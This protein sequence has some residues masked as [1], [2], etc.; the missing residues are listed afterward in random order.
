MAIFNSYVSHNQAGYFSP[1]VCWFTK[2]TDPR[3]HEDGHGLDEHVGALA[4]DHPHRCGGCRENP[5]FWCCSSG[6]VEGKSREKVM[7][8]R[9]KYIYNIHIYNIIHIYI[10]LIVPISRDIPISEGRCRFDSS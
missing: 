6:H 7:V 3:P 4:G 1:N 5:A 2:G 9:G 8:K 10:I